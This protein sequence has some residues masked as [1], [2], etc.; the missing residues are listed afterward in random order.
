MFRGPIDPI[1][2]EKNR[3]THAGGRLSYLDFVRIVSALWEKGHPDIPLTAMGAKENALYPSIVYRL[4]LRKPYDGEPKPRLREELPLPNGDV[5]IN[6]AQRFMNIVVFTCFTQMNPQ[7][8]E[9]II[10]EFE[11]FMMEFQPVFKELG[12]SELV[13]ERRMP[14]TQDNRENFTVIERA[15]A[16][17]LTT[18]KLVQTTYSHLN[19][20]FNWV[21][22]EVLVDARIK[23]APLYKVQHNQPDVDVE[24]IDTHTGATPDSYYII[25][26]E[27]D[28]A[29][30]AT[31]NNTPSSSAPGGYL[32]GYSGGDY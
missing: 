18:E 16:Y 22:N 20:S 29:D 15:V 8:A 7:L 1:R 30:A 24:I 28:D 9:A 25:E 10:E 4:D 23:E 11:N 31:P 27:E 5:V 19:N 26:E 32:V 17:R 21:L 6:S 2:V 13:Y 3:M 14:D 12:V